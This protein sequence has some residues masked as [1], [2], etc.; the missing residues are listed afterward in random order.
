MYLHSHLDQ[1]QPLIHFQMIMIRKLF[2]TYIPQVEVTDSI[3]GILLLQCPSQC[4]ATTHVSSLSIEI[5]ERD[6]VPSLMGIPPAH[7][8]WSP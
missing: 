6:R 7:V 2:R 8:A 1:K 3:L 5:P 4:T